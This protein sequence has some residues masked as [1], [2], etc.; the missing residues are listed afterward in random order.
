[1]SN[2]K[3]K[4]VDDVVVDVA[5]AK[6]YEEEWYQIATDTSETN[7]EVAADAVNRIYAEQGR[8]KPEI[9]FM[10]NPLYAMRTAVFAMKPENGGPDGVAN[11]K[12]YVAEERY[13]TEKADKVE[14]HQYG[15][16]DAYWL[17][18][19]NYMKDLHPELIPTELPK[20]GPVMDLSKEVNYYWLFEP[21]AILTVKPKYMGIV[22]E[23]FHDVDGPAIKFDDLEV[24]VLENERVTKE[25]WEKRVM[26]YKSQLGKTIFKKL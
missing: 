20:V 18:Y 26:P 6:K 25:E 10:P 3:P 17:V 4:T 2:N 24:Y 8:A 7:R 14:F 15:Q 16:L 19:W 1:M 22:N 13:K 12:K 9:I 5:L 11:V 21:L 23:K